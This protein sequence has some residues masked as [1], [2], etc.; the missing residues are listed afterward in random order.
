MFFWGIIL[1]G[2]R[3]RPAVPGSQASKK[4]NG[5]SKMSEL[6]TVGASSLALTS[7]DSSLSP[8]VLIMEAQTFQLPQKRYICVAKRDDIGLN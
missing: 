7:M 1:A 4:W 8:V 3:A 5:L 2:N 6:F